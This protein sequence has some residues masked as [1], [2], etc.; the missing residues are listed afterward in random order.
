MIL[1]YTGNGKGKTSACIGQAIRA[2]GHNLN[3]FFVQ[4]M[5]QDKQAGEQILLHKL[6]DKNFFAGGCGFFQ[7]EQD[8]AK[9]RDFAIK[10][11]NLAVKNIANANMII[12]DEIL[13]ALSAK[14]LTSEE[15]KDIINKANEAK[16]HLVLSGRNAPDWLVEYADLVTEMVEV[17]HPWQNGVVATMGIEF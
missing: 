15:I 1:I 2:M 4:F 3:V 14:L 7:K 10:T 17:K 5:K 11:Y 16:V 13:Y 12:L 9:H 6:L 8:R